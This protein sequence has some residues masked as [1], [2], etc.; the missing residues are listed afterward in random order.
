MVT[1]I[2]LVLAFALA[3]AAALPAQLS[4]EVKGIVPRGSFVFTRI[5]ATQPTELFQT[6]PLEVT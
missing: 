3:A 4:V 2:G 5:E 1:R 6:C